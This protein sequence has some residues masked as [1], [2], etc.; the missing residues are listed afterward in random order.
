MPLPAI[1]HWD[2][3]HWLVLYR[4]DAHARPP[5]RSGARASAACRAT[6]SRAAGPGY[7]AL[8]DYT[9]QFEQAPRAASTASPGCGRSSGRTGRLLWRAL[10]LAVI[11]SVLQMVLPVFTQVIVD[12]VLVEQDVSLLNLLDR[13]HGRHDGL[14]RGVARWR[15]ATCSVFAAVRIDA[16]GARLSHAAAAGAADA[17][18]SPRRRT[19][20]IQRRL[21]GIR[22][23]RDFLVQHGIAGVTAVAQLARRRS[24]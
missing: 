20:D 10:A 8:F 11:V 18:T 12:R 6:S 14:H 2:G 22:Q 16:G 5:R 9:P 15:S 13:R 3:D 4:R 7:A 1:A 21:E 24:R 23:V 17:R 19:G